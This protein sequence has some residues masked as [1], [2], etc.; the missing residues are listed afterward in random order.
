MTKSPN[1]RRN[2][3][4]LQ[5]LVHNVFRE[6]QEWFGID[7]HFL[8][9]AFLPLH[10]KVAFSPKRISFLCSFTWKSK[11]R[12]TNFIS[13]MGSSH[14]EPWIGVNQGKEEYQGWGVGGSDLK[15]FKSALPSLPQ[16]ISYWGSPVHLDFFDPLH[17][18][19]KAILSASI[20]T[21]RPSSPLQVDAKKPTRRSS[22]AN[23]A[24]SAYSFPWYFL[25]VTMN[26]SGSAS[27]SAS[28]SNPSPHPNWTHQ[29]YG[30]SELGI[31]VSLL[32]PLSTDSEKGMNQV[33]R[34]RKDSD[35][36]SQ[37]ESSIALADRLQEWN[38][39]IHRHTPLWERESQSSSTQG[40][41]PPPYE[42]PHEL[43]PVGLTQTLRT[44]VKVGPES[45][46]EDILGSQPSREV[47]LATSS[48]LWGSGP[49]KERFGLSTVDA[50]PSPSLGLQAESYT[51]DQ[52]ETP[53]SA[54]VPM[55]Q[56]L[57]VEDRDL[58]TDQGLVG[59]EERN[60]PE[61]KQQPQPPLL[62]HPTTYWE[63]G[64]PRSQHAPPFPPRRI[65]YLTV[66]TVT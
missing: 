25:D 23:Q 41:P 13:S 43:A 18:T 58:E 22:Q 55:A 40:I 15:I 3:I 19:P 2:S 33:L 61:P 24:P 27:A 38:E 66:R 64:S 28:A 17:L 57:E 16:F 49:S 14:C 6:D 8:R 20:D 51:Q 62:Q 9:L 54:L 10:Q 50:A 30:E 21:K 42:V 7:F 44:S 34:L 47:D 63:G 56:K 26:F 35:S 31:E 65:F 59:T 53:S 1:G 48:F 52:S 5:R 60:E 39:R 45:G 11:V 46:R 4:S 29:P 32:S 12:Y 37:N 36:D